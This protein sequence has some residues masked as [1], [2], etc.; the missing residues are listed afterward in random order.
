NGCIMTAARIPFA[1][2]RDGLFFRR[3]GRIHPGFQTPSFAIV[4]QGIWAGILVLSG[5]YET[6]FS[7]SMIAA[8]IFY[9]MTVGAVGLL[10]QKLPDMPRP[11]RMWGYPYTLLLF[12]V[13]SV[14]FVANA[15]I[16]QPVPSLAALA[17]AAT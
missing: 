8:W 4:L 7:Y 9:A 12:M 5:S 1:Q 13:V 2:A 16:T 6:L 17:I 10:R 3:F 11:Y 14:W 15:F